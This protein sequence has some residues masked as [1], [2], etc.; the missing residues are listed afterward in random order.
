M[1]TLVKILGGL[2]LS[3]CAGQIQPERA[4]GSAVEEAAPKHPV[5][6]HRPSSQGVLD[7]SLRDHGGR[8]IGVSCKTCHGSQAQGV[9]LG[10]DRPK[11]FHRG[12]QVTH[13]NL[14]CTACHDQD[15]SRLH[16][17]DGTKLEFDQTAKLCAQCHGVQYR[18][19]SRGSHGG[20][21]GYWDLQRGPRERNTCTD[22]HAAHSPAYEKVWPVHPP[23]DRFLEWKDQEPSRHE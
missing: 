16:L 20:M 14:T 10:E 18:D 7:T 21:T 1:S 9:L 19:Y 13:G 8:P 2:F 22:C 11:D 4:F 23:K 3:G 6:I 5:E 15:H 12:L 17:A